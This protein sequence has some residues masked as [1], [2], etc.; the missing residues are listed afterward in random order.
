MAR[1]PRIHL[2]GALYHVITR[3]NRRQGIFLDEKDLKTFVRKKHRGSHLH[4]PRNLFSGVIHKKVGRS[5]CGVRN[6]EFKT[7]NRMEHCAK[8]ITRV[9]VF[10]LAK[11]L[12]F[13]LEK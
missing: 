13:I 5:K 8:G 11:D 7:K 1:K 12:S 10:L 6:A 2:P 4:M 9:F 3:G